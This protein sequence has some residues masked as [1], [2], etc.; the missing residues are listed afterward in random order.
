MSELAVAKVVPAEAFRAFSVVLDGAEPG[1][2]E[3]TA[4]STLST[5]NLGLLLRFRNRSEP[6]E[7]QQ[8]QDDL[9]TPLAWEVALDTTDSTSIYRCIKVLGTA[10][11]VSM[12][13]HYDRDNDPTKLS[14]RIGLPGSTAWTVA[15]E[16][17]PGPLSG[18]RL[19]SELPL[20][21]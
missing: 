19:T 2:H 7:I 13:V 9:A 10:A 14:M 20:A 4:G 18:V 3:N 16:G 1:R 8:I 17:Q 6:G 21:R 12:G 5:V 11:S 15:N